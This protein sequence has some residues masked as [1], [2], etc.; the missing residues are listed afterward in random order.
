MHP[1]ALMFS[2]KPVLVLK[3][4]HFATYQHRACPHLI[5]AVNNTCLLYLAMRKLPIF[6]M[7]GVV[8]CI[9]Q[10][11]H[12]KQV[13]FCCWLLLSSG[14]VWG[15]SL[16]FFFCEKYFREEKKEWRFISAHSFR[17]FNPRRLHPLFWTQSKAEYHGNRRVGGEGQVISCPESR[18]QQNG[19]SNFKETSQGTTSSNRSR[20][21]SC[22]LPIP[23]N[24]IIL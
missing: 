7:V 5:L 15:F 22:F 19:I 6:F 11:D 9:E 3:G 23:N 20:L 17:D 2:S 21:L 16:C 18:E 8:L 10:S 14:W 24:A 1:I 13:R 4:E 12:C